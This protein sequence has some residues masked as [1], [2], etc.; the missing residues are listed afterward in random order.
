MSPKGRRTAWF[1]AVAAVVVAVDQVT[2]A[3]MRSFLAEGSSMT[4]VPGVLDLRLVY[5]EGAAFS[6]GEGFSWL[7][8]AVAV[9]IAVGSAL[10][11]LLGSPGVGLSAALGAVAGGGVGNLIDRAVSG[12]VT[13]FFMPTFTNFAVFNVADVAI[14]VGFAFALVL[15]WREDGR[16]HAAEEPATGEAGKRLEEVRPGGAG[17]DAR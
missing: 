4:L 1:L 14:T 7:F 8:M 13:D 3:F 11:V 6:L 12:C 17:G 15:F 5:N 2:K 9:A 16:R 10:Y